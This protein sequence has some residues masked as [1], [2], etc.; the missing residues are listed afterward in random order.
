MNAVA[1]RFDANSA[2]EQRY[3]T[4]DVLSTDLLADQNSEFNAAGPILR[5]VPSGSGTDYRLLTF[6]CRSGDSQPVANYSGL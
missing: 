1:H 5:H 2:G 6:L 3:L 4:E